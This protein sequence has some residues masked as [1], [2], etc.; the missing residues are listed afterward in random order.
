MTA[1]PSGAA[2]WVWGAA[3]VCCGGGAPASP[4]PWVPQLATTT[5]K[6]VTPA[7]TA[8]LL[9]LLPHPRQNDPPLSD[10]TRYSPDS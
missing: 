3:E 5:A 4:V 2:L 1:S 6:A 10:A 9:A 7:A 8:A